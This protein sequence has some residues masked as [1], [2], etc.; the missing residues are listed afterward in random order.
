[1]NVLSGAP[2]VQLAGIQ[3]LSIR[4]PLPEGEALPMHLPFGILNTQ[5]GPETSQL[6]A[7]SDATRMYGVNSFDPTKEYCNHATMMFNTINARGNV[8]FV[9]RFISPTHAKARVRLSLEIVTANVPLYKRN[10]DGSF[11]YTA[12]G[13]KVPATNTDG[14]AETVEGYNARWLVTPISPDMTSGVIGDG[15]ITVGS[16]SGGNGGGL[17]LDP[18]ASG[19]SSI[20]PWMDFEVSH[21]GIYGDNVGFAL[22]CPTTESASPVKEDVVYENEA[23]MYRLQFVER[24]DALSSAVIKP[25]LMGAQD[26]EFTFKKNTVDK[27]TDRNLHIDKVLPKSYR[28]VDSKGFSPIFGP[29]DTYH[30]YD[31]NVEVVLALLAAKENATIPEY[32]DAIVPHMFNPVKGVD[33]N[34]VPYNSFNLQGPEADGVLLGEG[35]YHYAKDGSDGDQTNAAF[36]SFVKGVFDNFEFNSVDEYMDSAEFPFSVFYD[37]GF[38]IDT[39]KSMLAPIGLRKDVYTVLSTQ[40]VSKPQNTAD[41]E[42]SI[43]ISLRAR[44]RLY[45]ESTHYGTSTCRAIIVGHSG[46]LLNSNYDKLLPLTVDFANKCAA[47]MGASNG[48]MKEEF[49]MDT[50]PL[51]NVT[52]FRDINC[53]YKSPRVRQKDWKAGLVH[54]QRKDRNDYFYPAYQTVYDNDS[55]VLNS[56]INMMIAVELEKVCERTWRNLTGD[57][58]LSDAQFFEKS[59][60]MIARYTEGRFDSRVTIIPETYKTEADALRGYSWSC[61]LHM[62]ANNMR[63]VGTYTV[64]ANRAEDLNA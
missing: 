1:M 4:I 6:V 61:K 5:R 43:A 28:D 46:K 49:S 41:E 9:R 55:S 38:S 39:K 24:P 26:V 11:L 23:L 52:M 19:D 30:V 29:M 48:S 58:K 13:A 57:T 37:S 18:D 14:L 33:V 36:D 40:D 53:V 34:K 32:Q 62:Y 51:N 42:M 47:Y 31:S 15:V 22:S 64:T 2:T 44:A 25:T 21:H 50:A 27:S 45:P 12:D 60:K 3:D 56:A 10:P 16:F 7:G 20:Y 59:D 63:T 54:V 35:V 17:V 8:Q